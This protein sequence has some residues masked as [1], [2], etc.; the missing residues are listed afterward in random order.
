MISEESQFSFSVCGADVPCNVGLPRIISEKLIDAGNDIHLIGGFI[1]NF[2][3]LIFF[4]KSGKLSKQKSHDFYQPCL[5]MTHSILTLA[6]SSNLFAH[7]HGKLKITSAFS[8]LYASFIVAS[9]RSLHS[10]GILWAN[11]MHAQ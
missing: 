7:T 10:I 9:S 2:P 3:W 11:C 8:S 6:I 1:Q 4:F 5:Q